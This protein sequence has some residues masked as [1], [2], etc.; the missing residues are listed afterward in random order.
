MG[1]AVRV[2]IA[3][4]DRAALALLEDHVRAWGYD[5]TTAH[6]GSAALEAIG[7]CPGI[8]AAIFNWMMPGIDGL[9]A[10]RRL[11]IGPAGG[12]HVI[13]VV[14][15]RFRKEVREGFASWADEYIPKPFDLYDLRVRLC[16]AAGAARPVRCRSRC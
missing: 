4:D 13:V 7:R 2:L 5:V 10:A 8:R 9:R 3:D 14:G 6:D 11:K 12:I 15:E 16:A 1:D